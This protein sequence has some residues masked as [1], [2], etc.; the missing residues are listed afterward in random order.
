MRAPFE[1]KILT[2]PPGR[3]YYGHGLVLIVRSEARR[4]WA[5]RYTKPTTRRVTETSIGSAYSFTYT[6]ARNEITRMRQLLAKRIDPV[7]AKRQQ[8]ASGTT[9]AEAWE[10]WI[11]NHRPRWRSTRHIDTLIKHGKPLADVPVQIIDRRMVINALSKLYEKHPEQVYRV[12]SVWSR[13]FDYAKTM[14]FREEDKANPCT[15][16]GNLEHVFH[17]P[18]NGNNH[19]AQMPFNDYQHSSSGCDCGR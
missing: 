12:A 3:Y 14:G 2:C 19:H 9:F 16:R 5:F 1:R 13:V 4:S 18:A 7:Q 6:D 11:N 8:Q 10:G 17:R 15:W